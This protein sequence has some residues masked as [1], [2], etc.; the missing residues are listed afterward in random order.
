[1]NDSTPDE[2]R[3][4]DRPHFRWL[5]YAAAAVA[6]VAATL[7][8]LALDPALGDNYPFATYFGAVAVMA[9]YGQTRPAAVA[10]AASGFVALYLFVP[11]HHT[12]AL[13]G[14][15]V[16]VG[17][18]LFL[19]V[20]GVIVA[21]GHAVR[22]ARSRT[23]R[24]LA[25]AVVRRDELQRA[26]EDRGEQAERLRTTLAS[27]GDAVISTD[28][29]GN[30]T[31]LNAVAESLT[32]WTN[33]DAAGVPLVQVFHIVNESTRRPVENP[34]ARALKE[35]VIVGLANHTVLIARDG[36]ERPIDDSA[37][38][39]RCKAGEI[40]G[41]VLVFRD[42]SE[43]KREEVAQAERTRLVGLRADVSTALTSARPTPDALHQCCEALVRHLGVAFARVWTADDADAVLELRAS[44]G[45]YTHLDGP[46]S[47]VPVGQFKIGRIASTRRP[48]LTNGVPG[49]PNVS[50]HEWAAREG[51][52]A[53]AGYP[54]MAEGRAVGVVAMF[55]RRPLSEGVLTE[56][57]PVADQIA[58][59]VRRKLA[60]ASLR[61]SDEFNRSLM[62]SSTDCIKVIDLD[63]RLRHM[64]AP[65]LCSM[66]IDDFGPLCGQPWEALWP[67]AAAE[68]I[69]RGVASAAA[70]TPYAFQAFC[71]TAKGTP[72]W[73]E[74]AVTPVRDTP[75]GRV[76]RLL[77]ASRDITARRE[78]EES[79][80]ESEAHFRNMADN[81]PA[82]LWVTDAAG[83][84][85][86][87]SRRWYEFT[88]RPAGGDV[89]SGWVDAV[90]PDEAVATNDRFLDAAGKHV[91]LAIDY[92]L[93]RYDGEYRWAVDAAFP[94]F[95]GGVFRGFV[96]C[97][98]D[99]HDRKLLEDELRVIAA[100]LS[101]ADRRKDEFLAILAH[102][103]RNP[104]APIRNGL[105]VM[106]LARGNGEAV[107][108]ARSMMERQLGQMVRLVD[109]LL[110]MS[111]INQGKLELRKERVELA[112]VVNSAV[113][114]SR[115][116]VEAGGHDLTVVIPPEPVFVDADPTRLAQVVANLLNNAAKYSERGG[117]ITLTAERR[118]DEA[119]VSVKDTGVGIPPDM[120]PKVFDLF[121]QVD[122]SLE[123]SQ[124]G[125]GIGLSL[126]RRLVDMH[127]G[128]VEA[129][130]DGHGKG[131]EFVVRVPV[132]AADRP[133]E[134]PA[135][136]GGAARPSARRILVA[137]DNVDSADSLGQ[138]L[139]LFGNEVRTAN[140]G[141]AAV[142]VAGDFRPDL[143]LLDIGMPR[144]NGYETC[145]RIREQAWGGTAYIVA[146]TG[147][148]QDD[149][150]RRSKE[151]GFDHHMVKPVDP[152]ALE[153]LLAGL[154]PATA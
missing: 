148:G 122:R 82:M 84:C 103:L 149:D 94:R 142:A 58:L 19:A 37:A 131:S 71:P 33:D 65:G 151:A 111:R 100:D 18:V 43:R 22:V 38:P 96:G 129:R 108:K 47:R 143:I 8:R 81:A 102:E 62:N 125:L 73:W 83:S 41:C 119:V 114:T 10:L 133:V 57:A 14:P 117:H 4:G 115:P 40:V 39:I 11:P 28:R 60:E 49:D 145:R 136:D 31:Y 110:D 147:W 52:V 91:P 120:L 154:Q 79:L 26:A 55:A 99:V 53:F 124:G 152:A 95:D 146:L 63:G 15:G 88:G 121:T 72:R 7:V 93:R 135:E 20:G 153:R 86:Y 137:D 87:R 132:V 80:R 48:H 51:M 128:T 34:A 85:T 109:D 24:L 70:G 32:G 54:L 64:N 76:V 68:E 116:L 29:G 9:W 67:P 59:Y 69:R 123:K 66:E 1:M 50:D 130:S 2:L 139:E 12:L 46:H 16:L 27:I 101:D 3:R 45:M 118:G 89:G 30:V 144:L 23:A 98:F 113:E 141:L 126:V 21:M 90:H 75:D 107:E 97:V 77:A 35:G 36:T 78:M 104:L 13:T 127:G 74:V 17:M 61:E 150:K 5:D 6:V 112:A 134:P 25:E 105:Q 44:A 42:I 138:L 92:R 140:D 56:L 106:R